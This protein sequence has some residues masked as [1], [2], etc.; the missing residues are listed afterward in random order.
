LCLDTHVEGINNDELEI[1]PWYESFYANVQE[2]I[3][4]A[5]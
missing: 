3:S 5:K 1:G 4:D 2:S